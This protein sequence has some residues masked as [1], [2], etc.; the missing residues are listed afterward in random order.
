MRL[1]SVGWEDSV[2]WFGAVFGEK[3]KNCCDED[4][5]LGPNVECPNRRPRGRSLVHPQMSA[6]STFFFWLTEFYTGL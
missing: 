1:Q 6:F 3:S 5:R 2:G 4:T